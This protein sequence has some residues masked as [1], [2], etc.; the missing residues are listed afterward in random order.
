M[1]AMKPKVGF[2]V[3]VLMP[4]GDHFLASDGVSML[5]MVWAK[6][7]RKQAVKV[8]NSWA[9]SKYNA[10]V[11]RVHYVHPVEIPQRNS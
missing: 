5:P 11:V 10:R 6:T 7:C 4:N 9:E 8:R 3:K 1:I 2:A